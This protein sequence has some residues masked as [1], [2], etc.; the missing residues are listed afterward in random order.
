MVASQSRHI[1]DGLQ[2][3]SRARNQSKPNQGPNDKSAVCAPPGHPHHGNQVG[4]SCWNGV[5]PRS[6]G[7]SGWKETEV[8]PNLQKLSTVQ[9]VSV[10]TAAGQLRWRARERF[11]A[12]VPSSWTATK[13]ATA[14]LSRQYVQ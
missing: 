1:P 11:L 14:R 13:S 6:S 9:L 10:L 8:H 3:A 7:G 12:A 4:L 5:W 2:T